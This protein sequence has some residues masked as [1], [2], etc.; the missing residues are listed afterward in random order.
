MAE[1]SAES[2]IFFGV[3]QRS[4]AIGFFATTLSQSLECPLVALSG[5]SGSQRHN[6]EGH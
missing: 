6:T 1:K 3:G 4:A 5:C 2:S